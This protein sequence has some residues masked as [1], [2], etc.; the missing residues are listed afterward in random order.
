MRE[1]VGVL[2]SRRGFKEGGISEVKDLAFK[3]NV[4]NCV[5]LF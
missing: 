1:I 4:I 5:K 2:V 3:R